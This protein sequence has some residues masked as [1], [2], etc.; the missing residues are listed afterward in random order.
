MA[1]WADLIG[2]PFQYGGRGPEF[3][4][5]YGLVMEMFRRDGIILPDYRSPSDKVTIAG[6]FAHGIQ[7]WES[8]EQKPGVAVLFRVPFGKRELYSHVGYLVSPNQVL[9]TTEL[10]NGV[11]CERLDVMGK[12]VHGFYRY[13]GSR[14]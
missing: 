3:Y 9:H 11:V 10:T 8:S 2:K 14:A 5:C 4:D 12:R 7:L 13:V 1:E 6:I